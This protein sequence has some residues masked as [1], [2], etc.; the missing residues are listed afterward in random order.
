[1]KSMNFKNPTYY[2]F[3]EIISIKDFDSSL[4]K[5]DKKALQ[6]RGYLLH[7]L[8]DSQKKLMILRALTV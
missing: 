7:W 5:L 6:K 4:L 1:M 3:N 8:C 2:F